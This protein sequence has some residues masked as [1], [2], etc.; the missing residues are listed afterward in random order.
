MKFNYIKDRIE[1]L[2]PA[3]GSIDINEVEVI[4]SVSNG[5]D[6]GSFRECLKESLDEIKSYKDK[7]EPISMEVI[8]AKILCLCQE[9]Y[10]KKLN[11][12]KK[13]TKKSMPKEIEITCFSKGKYEGWGFITRVKYNRKLLEE[14]HS[15][16]ALMW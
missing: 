8:P 9:K 15:P 3:D 16:G 1:T 7:R 2:C 6:E 13:M 5:I 14:Q 11:E 4:Y 12:N 10:M